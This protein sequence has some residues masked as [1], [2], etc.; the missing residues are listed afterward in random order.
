MFHFRE[1]GA[2]VTAGLDMVERAPRGRPA[3]RPRR[4]PHRPV[5]AQDGDVYGMTVNLASRIS[6]VAGTG[7]VVVSEE[8][9]PGAAGA[10]CGSSRWGRSS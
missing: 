2:A 7:Q 8:T 10:A 1:P 4:H 9:P 6:S 5:I 3:P